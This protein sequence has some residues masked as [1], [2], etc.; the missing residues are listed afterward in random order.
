MKIV[1]SFLF[2][3]MLILPLDFLIFIGLKKHYFDFY[4][5]DIYFNIY[6]FDNQPFLYIALISLVFGFLLLYTPLRK[7]LQILYIIALIATF[8]TLFEPIGKPLG[9]KIFRQNNLSCRLGKQT[10]TADLLYKGRQ[11][12]YFKREGIKNSIK[13]PIHELKID[14]E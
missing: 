12:Y 1:S 14:K 11:N 3:L 6:F 7:P 5:I 13:I 2:G 10:F 8:S 9:D 4:K